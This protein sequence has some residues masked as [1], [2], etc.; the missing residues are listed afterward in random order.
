[1]P[2]G[3]PAL[4]IGRRVKADTV[5]SLLQLR[6]Q[7]EGLALRRGP[8]KQAW[9]AIVRLCVGQSEAQTHG[10]LRSKAG[11]AQTRKKGAKSQGTKDVVG[12]PLVSDPMT[13]TREQLQEAL[14]CPASV[15]S[16]FILCFCP[17]PSP[18]LPRCSAHRIPSH[19]VALLGTHLRALFSGSV[20]QSTCPNFTFPSLTPP[21]T[22]QTRPVPCLSQSLLLRPHPGHH[23]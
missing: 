4:G 15:L 22:S 20:V 6:V 10:E 1:M 14:G 12:A 2:S 5:S 3:W 17:P 8:H 23:L 16:S 13:L 7:R 19:F 11:R 9:P 21:A 18:G